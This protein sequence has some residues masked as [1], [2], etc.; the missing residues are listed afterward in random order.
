MMRRG[1]EKVE[2]EDDEEMRKRRKVEGFEKGRKEGRV[3]REK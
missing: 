1:R 2:E 3:V